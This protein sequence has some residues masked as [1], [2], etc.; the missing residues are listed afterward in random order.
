MYEAIESKEKINTENYYDIINAICKKVIMYIEAFRFVTGRRD[1]LIY[2]L[3][4]G[5]NIPSFSLPA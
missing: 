3:L 5:I 4:I 1:V 2:F